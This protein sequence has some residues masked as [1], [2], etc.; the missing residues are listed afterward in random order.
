[1]SE[2]T[3]MKRAQTLMSQLLTLSTSAEQRATD[4]EFFEPLVS[5]VTYLR[6]RMIAL[7]AKHEAPEI[8]RHVTE[9]IDLSQKYRRSRDPKD[10]EVLQSYIAQ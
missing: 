8:A 9:L 1:M 4:A 6:E 5:D 7:I 3:A 10:L 2:E